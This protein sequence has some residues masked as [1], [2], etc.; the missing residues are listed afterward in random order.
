VEGYQQ[1]DADE[2]VEET[3]EW[4]LRKR[5]RMG[6]RRRWWNKGRGKD[7]GRDRRMRRGSLRMRDER[8][9]L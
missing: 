8:E 6:K 7:K 9:E 2:E 3:I 5:K 4:R 1:V